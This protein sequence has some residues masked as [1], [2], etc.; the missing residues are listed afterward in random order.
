MRFSTCRGG[1]GPRTLGDQQLGDQQ[2]GDQTRLSATV[3][4]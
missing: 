4:A 2:W 3:T 1:C